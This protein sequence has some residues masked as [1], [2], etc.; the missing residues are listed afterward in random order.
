MIDQH[1]QDIADWL[2]RETYHV[3]S[4]KIVIPQALWD[5]LAKAGWPMSGFIVNVRLPESET[6]AHE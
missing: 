3:P 6:P 2:S 1:L 5:I 4:G